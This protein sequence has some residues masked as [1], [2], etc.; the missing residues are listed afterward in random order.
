MKKC[1]F[2][3]RGQLGL[4][5]QRG[6]DPGRWDRVCLG[7]LVGTEGR[8]GVRGVGGLW[9]R[10][11]PMEGPQCPSQTSALKAGKDPCLSGS[12]PPADGLGE[13]HEGCEQSRKDSYFFP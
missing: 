11:C 3:E 12:A 7:P 4:E 1:V 10:S 9:E 8:A 5:L 13:V 6:G 2:V